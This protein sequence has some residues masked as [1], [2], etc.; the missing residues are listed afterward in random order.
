MASQLGRGL[1]YWYQIRPA[2]IKHD[3]SWVRHYKPGK[4]AEP[5]MT[6]TELSEKGIIKSCDLNDIKSPSPPSWLDKYGES[7]LIIRSRCEEEYKFCL[8]DKGL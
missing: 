1:F 8:H 4:P 3:C 6:E 2:Q 7:L 5:P